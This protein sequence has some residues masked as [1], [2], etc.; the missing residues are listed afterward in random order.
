MAVRAVSHP[1]T[2]QVRTLRFGR[3]VVRF[4]D[5][6]TGSQSMVLERGVIWL[7]N[8]PHLEI[9]SLSFGHQ[10]LCSSP[11][12]A[13]VGYGG[14]DDGGPFL[15]RIDPEAL[16]I[17]KDGG[18]QGFWRWLVPDV[19]YRLQLRTKRLARQLGG[20][21]VF[22]TGLTQAQLGLIGCCLGQ[23]DNPT[24]RHKSLYTPWAFF[25]G[26]LVAANRG[27]D[28]LTYLVQGSLCLTEGLSPS[29]KPIDLK[30]SA[31]LIACPSVYLDLADE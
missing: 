1:P 3:A 16:K 25:D 18:K 23:T 14:V 31:H 29:L 8:L 27:V 17:L 26:D 15:R 30:S 22:D 7:P 10:F 28:G 21:F 2:D 20:V 4:V 9:A 11:S 24:V 13:E 12:L 19:I 5:Q 6:W